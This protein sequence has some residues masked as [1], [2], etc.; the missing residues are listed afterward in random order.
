MKG[1]LRALDARTRIVWLWDSFQG[2]PSPR[3]DLYPTD[4]ADRHSTYEELAVPLAEV[5]AKFARYGSFDDQ[6][7]F[8]PGWFRDNLPTASIEK[9]SL[10][11]VD[12][13]MYESTMDALTAL[14]PKVAVG[15][16]VVI[17]DFGGCPV[18]RRAVEDYRRLQ[19]IREELVQMAWTG[20]YWRRARKGAI[21]TH[22]APARGRGHAPPRCGPARLYERQ[23]P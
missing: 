8:P 17:D 10:L 1:V 19:G 9:S 2:L 12:G 11:R 5:K 3:P 18:C 7:R 22:A 6:V 4:T 16:Y 15:G 14:N 23:R 20:V 21:I 13:D